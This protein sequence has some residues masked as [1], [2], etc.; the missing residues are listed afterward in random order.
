[1]RIGDVDRIDPQVGPLAVE[2][3]GQMDAD[4]QVER[5]ISRIPRRS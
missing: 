1:M 2:P 3:I 4:R 5:G